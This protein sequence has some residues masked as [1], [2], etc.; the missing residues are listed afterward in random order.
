MITHT[1]GSHQTQVKTKQSQ[2]YKFLQIAKNENFEILQETLHTT[3]LL[4][5]LHKMCKH[6]MDPTRVVGATERTWDSGRTD[7]RTEGWT[8]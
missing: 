8:E 1:S 2:S 3:H 4:N 6:E 5:L 7:G